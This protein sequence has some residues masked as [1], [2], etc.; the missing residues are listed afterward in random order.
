MKFSGVFLSLSGSAIGRLKRYWSRLCRL[1][2]CLRLDSPMAA[3]DRRHAELLGHLGLGFFRTSLDG[4]LLQVNQALAG[5]AGY[6]TAEEMLAG[7]TDVRKFYVTPDRRAELRS[8]VLGGTGAVTFEETFWRKRGDKTRGRVTLQIVR[9]HKNR[10]LYLEG[11]VED[12]T[13]LNRTLELADVQ[14]DLGDKLAT[15]CSLSQALRPCLETAIRLANMDSGEIYLL[16][17]DTRTP[18]LAEAIGRAASGAET[19]P[20]D[21]EFTSVCEGQAHTTVP[22]LHED[23][24][25]GW[26]V[27]R[28]HT[29][30]EIPDWNH[31]ALET[32][33][34]QIGSAIVRIQG[35][36]A[37]SASQRQL[38]ALFDSLNDFLAIS[39]P[40]GYILDANKSLIE[41]AGSSQSELRGKHLADIYSGDVRNRFE[42]LR[43][44]NSGDS[45]LVFETSL[46][47]DGTAIPVEV[48]LSPG[49]WDRQRVIVA[50]GRD[51]SERRRSEAQGV[52]LREKTALLKEIHHRV[53]NN[54]QIVS[55]LLSLQAGR[56]KSD[57]E[58]Q[59]FRDSQVRVQ[60]MALLHEQ[61]YQS[62][63]LSRIDFSVYLGTLA[64]EVLRVSR[65][66][67]DIRLRL[68]LEPVWANS[69]IATPCGLIVNELITNSC[70]YA[71]PG[72]R[73]E[74]YLG[75]KKDEQH[76]MIFLIGDDGVGLPPEMDFR[77]ASTL[78]LQ[79]VDDM[80]SQL[81]GS[82]TLEPCR[83]TLFR[84]VVPSFAEQG[85]GVAHVAGTDSRR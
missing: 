6:A 53:K 13:V 85:N 52:A 36:E 34:A 51:L 48:R 39:D 1:K 43:A 33:A 46:G 11:A 62:Q 84:I 38:R 83:G 82:W 4:R 25:I 61:L 19:S 18:V 40:E 5:W 14:R 31:A 69:E 21:V 41:A 72:H 15:A 73:G 77:Q 16:D 26:L 12:T 74:I 24:C 76:N 37:V 55:S 59:P 58:R 78:G 45:S 32:I 56:I 54:L 22:I 35:Q 70:K 8:R 28:S 3:S 50:V 75:V 9:D 23:A 17:P 71:F 29:L 42:A 44:Q 81:K 2:Q 68:E 10:P 65:H 67:K 79:L 63:D 47:R 30:P 64:A 57:R 20:Q 7:V 80:V 66:S 49:I 27:T 60:A